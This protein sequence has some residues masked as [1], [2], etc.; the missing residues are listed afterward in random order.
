MFKGFVVGVLAVVVL[1]VVGGFIAIKVGMVPANA[2]ARPSLFERWIASTSLNASIERG[3]EGVQN[4]LQATDDNVLSGIKLYAAHCAVCHGDSSGKPTYI[5]FGLYQKAPMLGRHG[6]EDDPDAETYWK[7]TH[8][9][10][11]TGMPSF[12]L[13]LND[14]Q[15]WQLA[16]FLKNMDKLSAKPEIAWKK[17][18]APSLPEA[19]LRTLPVMRRPEGGENSKQRGSGSAVTPT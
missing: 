7:V 9:I 12:G 11:L 5:G 16:T 4:P 14:T 15:R 13:T 17:V 3:T 18:T 19:I 6:V 8:G 1:V 2:D 10:R